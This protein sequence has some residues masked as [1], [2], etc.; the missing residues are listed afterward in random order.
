[1][2]DSQRDMMVESYK[3]MPLAQQ[4]YYSLPDDEQVAITFYQNSSAN[5]SA[6]R[7]QKLRSA[8]SKFKLNNDIITYR[9]MSKAE[10]DSIANSGA[11]ENFKSTSADEQTAANFAKNQ[12]GYM[13][14]YHISKG[15]NVA[16]LSGSPNDSEKEYLIN[17]NVKYSKVVKSGDKRLIVY[18]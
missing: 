7:E 12:G 8:I 2:S 3:S 16:D 18:I 11:T 9:G 14:E 15:S 1:M 13:V 10:F 5:I 4:W 17:K 6:E